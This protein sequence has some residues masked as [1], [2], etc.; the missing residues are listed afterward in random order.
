MIIIMIAD[1]NKAFSS[2]HRKEVRTEQV[3]LPLLKFLALECIFHSGS[4]FGGIPSNT[5]YL[6]LTPPLQPPL[7]C[8]FFYTAFTTF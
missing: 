3:F 2:C 1:A 6:A 8:F 4:C 5:F 7:L